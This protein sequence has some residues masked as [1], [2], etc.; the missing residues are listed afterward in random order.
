MRAGE[1]RQFCA[2]QAEGVALSRVEASEP[3]A[4]GDIVLCMSQMNLSARACHRILKFARTISDLA[5][6][7]VIQSL[8]LVEALHAS[9]SSEVD[10]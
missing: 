3:D 6:C 10:D 1:I 4:V 9:P 7:D 8:H 5:G 2:L